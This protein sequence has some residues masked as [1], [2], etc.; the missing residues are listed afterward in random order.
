MIVLRDKLNESLAEATRLASTAQNEKIPISW[1]PTEVFLRICELACPQKTQRSVF[2]VIALTHVCRRWRDA[3]LSYPI[4]WSHIYVLHNSPE[5]LLTTVLQRSQEVPLT[6]NIR[7]S[8]Y[9]T[10]PSACGCASHS[11]WEDGDYCSHPP[12][13]QMS[14][15]DFL[16]PFRARVH[17]LNVRYLRSG[18]YSGNRMGDIVTTPFFLESFPNLESLRWSCS[19]LGEMDWT[20]TIF[21]LPKRLFGSSLPRLQKLSMVNCWG[22]AAT[23]TP[24]LRVVSMERNSGVNQANI[25]ASKFVHWFRGRQSL[26]SLSLANFCIVPDAKNA[27]RPVSLKKL[28]EMILQKVGGGVV[29]RYIRCPSIRRITTLRIAPSSQ[30]IWADSWTVSVTA[31]DGLG[32]SISSLAHLTNDAPLT[33]TWNA[34]A[35]VFQHSV[36]TLEIE[37]LH[38]ILSGVTAIPKLMDVLPD[39]H[40]IRI[41]VPPVAKEFKV[42]REIL[43]HKHGIT[44]IERLVGETENLD[45]ARRN[46]EEW[47]AL[48][49]E[50]RIHD[51]LA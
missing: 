16:E 26:V 18:R 22:L 8:S 37:D 34:F 41:R 51:C 20:I 7:Y 33:E 28:K 31:T 39:L 3:L 14:S 45:E 5:P 6:I 50:H 9:L 27:P 13:R 36:T 32:G 30:A 25:S 42:L 15:L 23:D 35:L 10:S 21:T 40:I 47:E 24:V 11:A 2:D 29:S 38:L 43:S 17:T 44:R 1:L 49:I 46:D 19:Y 48:C 4:I 12:T